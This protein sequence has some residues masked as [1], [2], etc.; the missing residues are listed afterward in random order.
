M[1]A[2]GVRV[3]ELEAALAQETDWP[4]EQDMCSL[5]LSLFL[6]SFSTNLASYPQL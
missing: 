2:T 1:A 3:L 4:R 6:I 5:S